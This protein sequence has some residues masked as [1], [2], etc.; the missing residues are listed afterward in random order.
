M[1]K[2]IILAMLSI[3]FS[4]VAQEHFA[5]LNTSSR[6]GILN[7]SINPAELS[8]M[9]NKFEVN[10]FGASFNVGNNKI[11][12]SDLTSNTNLED[13]IFKGSE[14][15]NLRFDAEIYGLGLALKYKKWSF[16]ITSKVTAKMGI[17]DIDSKIGDAISNSGLDGLLS[18]TSINNNYNQRINGTTFGEI[19]ISGARNIIDN[20]RIKFNVGATFKLLFPG[21][22]ANL[23]LDKFSGTIT[24]TGTTSYVSGVSNASL[25][26]AYS[27]GLANS[28]SNFDDYSKSVW[29]SMNG[30]ATDFGVN[31]Q[32]KERTIAIDETDENAVKKIKNNFKNKYKLNAGMSIR[33]LGSMTFKDDN[34]YSTN[35]ILNIPTATLTNPG[36]DLSLF[37][38]VES[39]NEVETILINEG[40]LNK[41]QA[42]KK[43]FKVN[44][45]TTFSAYVDLKL[46]SKVFVTG[47]IQQ[48]LTDDSKN[49]QVTVQNVITIT[50]RFNTG[51]FEVYVPLSNT[52]IS[53]FNAGFGFRLGGFYLG[54]GSIL[55]AVANDSK[56][57]DI[58]TGF[59]WSFL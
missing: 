44:L 26:I 34:N 20:E 2:S 35:Y 16:G 41:T 1:K 55:T 46:V 13:L 29:G 33:N 5:G 22:Y 18:T 15:V 12:F 10:V 14:P 6:V 28:F 7:A 47:F 37:E 50:P 52:E 39:L 24:N 19:G 36:L 57:A 30:F 43:D 32:L 54:S 3:G 17:I 58:Y 4:G 25:N 42:E 56:Q 53:G 38:N 8:N 59:R 49:D 51:F 21:S 9:Y 23:G 11:G 27:G 45:P 40:Y 48:K 31:F